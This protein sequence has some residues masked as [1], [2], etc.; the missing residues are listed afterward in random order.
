[1]LKRRE[2]EREKAEVVSTIGGQAF[3][4]A[5]PTWV[6]HYLVSHYAYYHQPFVK[7]YVLLQAA[8]VV[9]VVYPPHSLH[10]PL[11]GRAC[12]PPKVIC[13]RMEYIT[14]LLMCKAGV[15]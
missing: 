5:D 12:L 2:R 3:S 14:R 7:L 13:S 11:V 9:H 6:P 10:T 1:M 15:P 8:S 4:N